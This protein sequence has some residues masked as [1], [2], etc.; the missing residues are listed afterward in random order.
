MNLIEYAI[1][2][3]AREMNQPPREYHSPNRIISASVSTCPSLGDLPL[4]RPF[5]LF[6]PASPSLDL[7]APSCGGLSGRQ[8]QWVLTQAHKPQR[9][10]NVIRRTKNGRRVLL[11]RGAQTPQRQQA[12]M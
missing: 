12:T 3:A 2:N 7:A 9:E 8:Q 6:S 1:M 11:T 5:F 10:V 4:L